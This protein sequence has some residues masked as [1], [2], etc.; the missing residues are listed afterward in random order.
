MVQPRT[1]TT[2]AWAVG[3]NRDGYHFHIPKRRTSSNPDS[4]FRIRRLASVF[5]TRQ[6]HWR[7]PCTALGGDFSP[8]AN[9][10]RQTNASNPKLTNAHAPRGHCEWTRVWIYL[11]SRRRGPRSWHRAAQHP[12]KAPMSNYGSSARRFGPRVPRV[13][14][15]QPNEGSWVYPRHWT[16]A[17]IGIP[18]LPP[19]PRQTFLSISSVCGGKGLARSREARKVWDTRVLWSGEAGRLATSWSMNFAWWRTSRS[20]PLRRW[21]SCSATGAH[22][23][24]RCDTA[25][26]SVARGPRNRNLARVCTELRRLAW[27]A[28]KSDRCGGRLTTSHDQGWSGPR[29][30]TAQARGTL[31]LIFFHFSSSSFPNSNLKSNIVSSLPLN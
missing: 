8:P 7:Q 2:C 27:R 20:W 18:C 22:A 10:Y 15:Q 1:R 16:V 17:G 3:S 25:R 29:A 4:S 12:N 21:R 5:S 11:G 24:W 30:E 6:W 31:L 28:H 26:E 23:Q 19:P 9:T 13:P 14:T